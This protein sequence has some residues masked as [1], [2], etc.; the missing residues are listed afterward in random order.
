MFPDEGIFE[1]AVAHVLNCGS[2]V[3]KAREASKMFAALTK[4][5]LSSMACGATPDATACLWP[6]C[7]FAKANC[8][9]PLLACVSPVAAASRSWQTPLSLPNTP[10]QTSQSMCRE[11]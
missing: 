8:G 5:V 6:R 11:P 10:C 9:S 3:D 2:D 7:C 4:K 1:R